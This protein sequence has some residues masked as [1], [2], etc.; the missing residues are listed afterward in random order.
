MDGK[1]FKLKDFRSGETAPPFHPW[2]RGDTVPYF[3]DDVGARAARDN[4]GKT[5]YVPQDMKY[6]EWKQTFVE[7]G[8]KDGLEV[9]SYEDQTTYERKGLKN[10]EKSGIIQDDFPV[11]TNSAIYKALGEPLY[12]QIH[13]IA[14]NAPDL[15]RAIWGKME[16][17]LTVVSA[18]SKRHPCCHRTN[19]IEMDVA[20]SAKGST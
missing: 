2:C 4:D 3:D 12:T 7:N 8:S 17:R 1:I 16:S 14:K 15:E 9:K 20:H 6:P 13:E 5:Y 18:T 19:G 11:D 10:D